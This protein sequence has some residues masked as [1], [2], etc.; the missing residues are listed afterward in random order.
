MKLD[1]IA[2]AQIVNWIGRRGL[3]LDAGDILDM[4]NMID[5]K[6]PQID[7]D[8]LHVKANERALQQQ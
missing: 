7:V 5:V 8:A 1:K 6:V 3:Q 2:F 4:D